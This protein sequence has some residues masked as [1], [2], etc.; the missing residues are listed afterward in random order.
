MTSIGGSGSDVLDGLEYVPEKNDVRLRRV[1]GFRVASGASGP[2][3]HIVV[4]DR[5]VA[6]AARRQQSQLV[7]ER[8]ERIRN[9]GS[10]KDVSE[11]CVQYFGYLKVGWARRCSC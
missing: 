3:A 5:L 6:A 11:L 4:Q 9:I 2:R 1:N 7:I 10:N 8:C